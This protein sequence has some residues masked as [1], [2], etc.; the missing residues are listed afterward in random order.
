MDCRAAWPRARQL[1]V[2]SGSTGEGGLLTAT[3]VRRLGAG[4]MLVALMNC[5]LV[6]AAQE[7]GLVTPERVLDTIELR[8][9]RA[10][11]EAARRREREQRERGAKPPPAYLSPPLPGESVPV[12]PITPP[13]QKAKPVPL[14]PIAPSPEKVK[15]VPLRPMVP[16]SPADRPGDMDLVLEHL[17]LVPPRQRIG[18]PVMAVAIVRNHGDKH[19]RGVTLRFFLGQPV[20]L[21]RNL[22]VCLR[23]RVSG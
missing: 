7:R 14:R 16:P 22:H 11:E 3:G 8:D 17:E 21:E 18:E 1:R 4:I 23:W 2:F 12:R 10:A 13:P 6:S 9:Q 5:A 20:V 19:L 15:P